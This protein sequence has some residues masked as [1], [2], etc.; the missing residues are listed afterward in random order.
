MGTFEAAVDKNLD[1]LE[2]Q[3][4]EWATRLDELVDSAERS[5]QQAKAESRQ[6]L[7]GI[8]DK[9]SDAEVKLHDLKRAESGKWETFKG[10]LLVALRDVEAAFDALAR[11]PD[12]KRG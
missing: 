4:R 3:L 2:K 1:R 10:D 6:R 11:P 9:L 8:R 5:G 12:T 7:D